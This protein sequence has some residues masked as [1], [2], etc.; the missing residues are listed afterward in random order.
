MGTAPTLIFE[1]TPQSPVLQPAHF[2]QASF[3]PRRHRRTGTSSLFSAGKSTY[4]KRMNYRTAQI[5][6]P[7]AW[8]RRMNNIRGKVVEVVNEELM[9]T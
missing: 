2:Q 9:L 4:R 8:V 5:R 3:P 6:R 7:N 1:A